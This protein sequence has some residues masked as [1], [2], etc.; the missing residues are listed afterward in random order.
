MRI[1]NARILYNFKITSISGKSLFQTSLNNLS[2]TLNGPEQLPIIEDY[3]AGMGWLRTDGKW[4]FNDAKQLLHLNEDQPR[5]SLNDHKKLKRCPSW[6]RKSPTRFTTHRNGS[7]KSE[8]IIISISQCLACRLLY[9]FHQKTTFILHHDAVFL[10]DECQHDKRNWKSWATNKSSKRFW[11]ICCFLSASYPLHIGLVSTRFAGL[12]NSQ[13][14]WK[15][16][17]VMIRSSTPKIIPWVP[18]SEQ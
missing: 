3:E 13:Y 8:R 9:S 10:K 14:A 5:L 11:F 12:Q 18:L 6:R 17:I 7:G 15:E 2:R 4:L 1:E 16:V